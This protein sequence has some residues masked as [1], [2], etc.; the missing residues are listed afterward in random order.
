M[1]FRWL[2]AIV[3]AG[4]HVVPAPRTGFPLFQQSLGF[5]QLSID[6]SLGLERNNIHQ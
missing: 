1:E 2:E 5:I 6:E 4:Q 3:A